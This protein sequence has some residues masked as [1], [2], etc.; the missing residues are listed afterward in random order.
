[1][2]ARASGAMRTIFA[3]PKKLIAGAPVDLVTHAIIALTCKKA[4]QTDNE[5]LYCNIIDP[6]THPWTIQK[7]YDFELDMTMKYPMRNQLWWPYC[8][9]TKNYLYFQYRRICYHYAPAYWGDMWSRL[10]GQ[11]PQ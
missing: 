8:P 10:F 11:K 3:D 5:V 4:L 2:M 6:D 9:V 7:Y 1:M